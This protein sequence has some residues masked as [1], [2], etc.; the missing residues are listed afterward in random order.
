MQ[1]RVGNF[2][3]FNMSVRSFTVPVV[4]EGD[5]LDCNAS[6]HFQFKISDKL[7]LPVLGDV[8]E[9]KESENAIKSDVFIKLEIS[10]NGAIKKDVDIPLTDDGKFVE[11]Y[12]DSKIL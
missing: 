7:F 8:N 9:V 3:D 4:S 2:E 12:L 11:W 5:S 10:A 1:Y 6:L